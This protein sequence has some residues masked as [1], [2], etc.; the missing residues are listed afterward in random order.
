MRRARFARAIETGGEARAGVSVKEAL[1]FDLLSAETPDDD[2]L[3][4]WRVSAL[5][6]SALLL[7]VTHLLAA[8]GI[9]ALDPQRALVSS[10]ANPVLP[11]LALLALDTAAIFGLRWRNRIDVD[12]HTVI[13]ALCA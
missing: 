1:W 9:V 3:A 2:A 8:V 7:G 11:M 5:D 12:Q 4:D 13:S 6:H 10:F